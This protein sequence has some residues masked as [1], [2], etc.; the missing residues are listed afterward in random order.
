MCMGGR[1]C[2]ADPR[3]YVVSQSARQAETQTRKQLE[4]VSHAEVQAFELSHNSYLNIINVDSKLS[5]RLG[6]LFVLDGSL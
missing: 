3:H 1:V 6:H 2:L 4:E 5:G